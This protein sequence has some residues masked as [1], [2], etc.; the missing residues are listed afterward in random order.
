MNFVEESLPERYNGLYKKDLDLFY[1]WLI[2]LIEAAQCFN[3]IWYGQ[4]Q[5]NSESILKIC[6]DGMRIRFGR[7]GSWI[8]KLADE[9]IQDKSKR[10]LI[11][12][13]KDYK[14]SR[15]YPNKKLIEEIKQAVIKGT[16]NKNHT[17]FQQY[18]NTIL[19]KYRDTEDQLVWAKKRHIT[20]PNIEFKD[21]VHLEVRDSKGNIKNAG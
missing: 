17:S 16:L 10:L 15:I 21:S 20:E 18:Y 3:F 9:S 7:F 19:K 12:D 8:D 14:D 2:I 11:R 1:E 4:L 6:S 13:K 5:R